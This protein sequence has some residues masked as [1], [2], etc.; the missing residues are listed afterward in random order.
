ML[1]ASIED[2]SGSRPGV[3]GGPLAALAE[4]RR[5]RGGDQDATRLLD[6]AGP[7]PAAQ[8]CR[9]RLALDRGE[10]L[11]AVE[12]TERVLRQLPSHLQLDRVPALE[13]LVCARVARG[14][15][16]EA[17]ETVASLRNI[18]GLVRTAASRIRRPG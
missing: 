18:A 12:L 6:A 9:A 11:R 2:F 3:T 14:E 7:T 15:L 4:L 5:L 10:T 8:L 13:L 1:E 16:D 17:R